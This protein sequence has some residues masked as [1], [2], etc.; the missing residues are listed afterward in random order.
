MKI[1]EWRSVNLYASS[2]WL[3]RAKQQNNVYAMM[4]N[5]LGL[6]DIM[7]REC[8][9]Q[10]LNSWADGEP[11]GILLRLRGQKMLLSVLNSSMM[12]QWKIQF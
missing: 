9:N 6:S 2:P 5:A 7:L 3:G 4:I 11:H 1:E 12:T 10:N 8:N